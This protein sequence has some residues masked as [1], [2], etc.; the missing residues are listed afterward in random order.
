M[1]DRK[2]DNKIFRLDLT[3]MMSL[4]SILILFLLKSNATDVGNINLSDK[5]E[6]PAST[7]VIPPKAALRLTVSKDRLMV[8]DNIVMNIAD[9]K[10]QKELL[11]KPLADTLGLYTKKTKLIGRYNQNIKFE[12]NILLESDKTIDFS[13]I[14]KIMYTSGQAGYGRISMLVISKEE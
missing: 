9:I 6:L 12:G 10:N 14:K 2:K 1:R 13:I 3:A 8:E 7:S 4:F 11:L 5:L